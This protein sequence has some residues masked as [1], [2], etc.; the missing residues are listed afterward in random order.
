MIVRNSIV[1]IWK[2]FSGRNAKISVENSLAIPR[3]RQKNVN[4]LLSYDVNNHIYSKSKS[5]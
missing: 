3:N 4:I 5:V 2:H 1:K